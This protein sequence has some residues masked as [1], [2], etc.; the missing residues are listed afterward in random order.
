MQ[1][2]KYRQ[3]SCEISANVIIFFTVIGFHLASLLKNVTHRSQVYYTE[4]A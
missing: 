3:N 2:L 1:G 4:I